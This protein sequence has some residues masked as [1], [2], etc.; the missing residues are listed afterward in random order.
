MDLDLSALRSW[1][2]RSLE[3][4]DIV[5]PRLV[6]EYR[7]TLDPNLA[8]VPGSEAP[9]A[10]HWCLAPPITPLSAIGGDGHAAKG[11]FLPP[12]PL[13]RRM[14][15]GG[16]VTTH[17]PL[18]LGDRVHRR[19]VIADVTV[20]Q[21]RTG[22]LCFVSIDHDYSTKRGVALSERHDIVYRDAVTSAAK[23]E[24]ARA[25]AKPRAADLTWQVDATPTLLFRYSAMTFNGHRIHYD[26]PYVTGVEG[27]P[28]LVVHGPLQASL[29]FNLAAVLGDGVPTGFRYRGLSPLFSG[30]RFAIRGI[31]NPEGIRC[32]T[33]DAAGKICMESEARIGS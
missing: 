30:Q 8:A 7:A 6:A 20:K 25:P 14:W 23:P 2:G 26:Q 24:D 1:I 15:A 5:T 12:V 13:P 22:T 21:G 31:R 19:S 17:G 11:E 4:D 29:M 18:E 27:Y 28:G 33:E 3:A 32:W 10:L 9:L 16:S